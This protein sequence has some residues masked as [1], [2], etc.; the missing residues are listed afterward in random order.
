MQNPRFLTPE[1]TSQIRENYETPLYVY[2]E[3]ELRDRA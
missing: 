3:Q 2:S 1:L